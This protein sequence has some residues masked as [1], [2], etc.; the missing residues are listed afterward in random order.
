MSLALVSGRSSAHFAAAV[1]VR[2]NKEHEESSALGM[3]NLMDGDSFTNR[4]CMLHA[5]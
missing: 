4:P 2:S 3:R 1:G 5:E